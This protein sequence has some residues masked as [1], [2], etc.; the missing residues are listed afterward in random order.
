M[1]NGSRRIIVKNT[2]V[3]FSMRSYHYQESQSL[4]G[5]SSINARRVFGHLYDI[6]NPRFC[7]SFQLGKSDCGW[8]NL[9]ARL[10]FPFGSINVLS[11]PPDLQACDR[12]CS[13]SQRPSLGRDSRDEKSA[14]LITCVVKRGQIGSRSAVHISFLGAGTPNQES[15]ARGIL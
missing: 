1:M 14:P 3:S 2:C 6:D 5:R 10:I 9:T 13:P 15:F 4:K 8:R 11:Y 12:K 7:N